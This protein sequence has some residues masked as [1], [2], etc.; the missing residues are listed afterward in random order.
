MGCVQPPFAGVVRWCVAS[1]WPVLLLSAPLGLL[2]TAAFCAAVPSQSTL[3]KCSAAPVVSCASAAAIGSVRHPHLGRGAVWP[4]AVAGYSAQ[5]DRA[6]CGAGFPGLAQSRHCAHAGPNRLTRGP[7]Q[8]VELKNG[9]TYNGHLQSCDNWMNLNLREVTLTS[10]VGDVARACS[11][12][13]RASPCS[14]AR[15]A[16]SPHRQTSPAR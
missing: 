16:S 13:P 2:S 4:V 14:T 1:A 12:H 11:R 5:L 7:A 6:L 15:P 9:E 8:L 3:Q 10:R